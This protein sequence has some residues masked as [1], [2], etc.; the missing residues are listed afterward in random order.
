[1]AN[2]PSLFYFSD[3]AGAGRSTLFTWPAQGEHLTGRDLMLMEVRPSRRSMM[4]QADKRSEP[5]RSFSFLV[6]AQ[7]QR[8]LQ[9]HPV[10]PIGQDRRRELHTLRIFADRSD[11][12][13]VELVPKAI[14]R[15]VEAVPSLF[16]SQYRMGAGGS[17]LFTGLNEGAFVLGHTSGHI[18]RTSLPLVQHHIQVKPSPSS[19]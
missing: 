2:V 8:L 6:L 18:A 13:Q 14:P 9:D 16:S 5:S 12:L 17:T 3:R 1:M 7:P 11:L 19:S 15:Q 10:D 4:Y